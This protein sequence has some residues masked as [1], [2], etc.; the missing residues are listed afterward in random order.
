VVDEAALPA[1][2]LRLLAEVIRRARLWRSEGRD[3]ARELC[4]HFADGVRAGRTPTELV[5][6]FGPI[7]RSAKLIARASRR[8]RPLWWKTWRWGLKGAACGILMCMALY[9]TLFVAVMAGKPVVARPFAVEANNRLALIPELQRAW[10]L[11]QSIK[12][13]LGGVPIDLLNY[14]LDSEGQINVASGDA[15]PQK[16]MHARWAQA[17]AWVDARQEPIARLRRTAMLPTLGCPMYSVAG[18][19][20]PW[21]R[22]W[23]TADRGTDLTDLVPAGPDASL[24]TIVLPFT[25]D[26]RYFSGILVVDARRAI[27]LRDTARFTADADALIGLVVQAGENRLLISQLVRIA[28]LHMAE[29]ILKEALDADLLDEAMLTRLAHR[30]GALGEEAVRVT[31]DGEKEYLLDMVQRTYTDDGRGDGHIT[32]DGLKIMYSVTEYW[33]PDDPDAA[34]KRKH[35]DRELRALSPLALLTSAGRK[36][37]ISLVEKLYAEAQIEADTPLWQ[38]AE[39]SQ[40][41]VIARLYETSSGI[42]GRHPLLSVLLPALGRAGTTSQQARQERD[43][44]LVAIAIEVYRRKHGA[45]PARLTDLVPDLLPALPPDIFDGKSIKYTLAGDGSAAKP[46]LYSV[47][48]DRTDNGGLGP[49]DAR[50]D[51]SV[52]TYRSLATVKAWLADPRSAA[53]LRGDWI[54]YDPANAA[55]RLPDPT[56]R[57]PATLSAP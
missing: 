4:A 27:E 56:K 9:A 20:A 17:A 12:K 52:S 19:G 36:E 2:L 26:A 13:D 30:L 39:G 38:R 6:A 28:V 29:E 55:G 5:E 18:S 57:I 33:T 43:A 24:F 49:A 32:Y 34:E 7:N 1:E 21:T 42:T 25:Y 11:Y 16:Y 40:D 15:W 54:L 35:R 44:M 10:P 14:P 8:K 50:S 31:F 51:S 45:L 23:L 53:T 48:A 47:G 37:T 3:V 22:S 41:A 46:V